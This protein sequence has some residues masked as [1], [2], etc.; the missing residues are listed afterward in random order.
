[1]TATSTPNNFFA[2]EQFGGV[3]HAP[4]NVISMEEMR[5]R[6]KPADKDSALEAAT[7]R[8]TPIVITST[9]ERAPRAIA[10]PEKGS[11]RLLKLGTAALLTA[12]TITGIGQLRDSDAPTPVVDGQNTPSTE[13]S[14]TT[15]TSMHVVQRG[16]SVWGIAENMQKQGDTR[17]PRDAVAE[18]NKANDTNGLIHPGERLV[19]PLPPT[20]T[21]E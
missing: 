16:E 13:V 12:G 10:A 20:M 3:E 21:Q 11:K 18:I 9:P 19:V 15:P 4:R 14:P 5:A 7:N 2:E 1:M 6:K 17:D 8:E